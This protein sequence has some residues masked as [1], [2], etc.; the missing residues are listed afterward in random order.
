MLLALC[1]P[2]T[3][4]LAAIVIKCERDYELTRSMYL[5]RLAVFI[6]VSMQTPLLSIDAYIY[7]TYHAAVQCS[8]RDC[9]RLHY[10]QKIVET[11]T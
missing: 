11:A 6:P 4:A 1:M 3:A 7:S 10:I 2:V 8:R 9:S 5:V